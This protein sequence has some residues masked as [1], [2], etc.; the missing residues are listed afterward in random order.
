MLGGLRNIL[1]E[2]AAGGTT[3]VVIERRVCRHRY[4][5]GLAAESVFL[6]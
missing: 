4:M 6:R 1:G 3:A 2:E 5:G